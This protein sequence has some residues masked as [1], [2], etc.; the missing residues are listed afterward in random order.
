[1][2]SNTNTHTHTHHTEPRNEPPQETTRA[3]PHK[4]QSPR[5]S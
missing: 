5:P 2:L 3:S 1:M 4:M